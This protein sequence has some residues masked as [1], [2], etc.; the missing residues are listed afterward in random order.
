VT[1]LLKIKT[2]PIAIGNNYYICI[3]NGQI[4]SINL[5]VEFCVCC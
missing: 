3:Y 4:R 2:D 5:S 1:F